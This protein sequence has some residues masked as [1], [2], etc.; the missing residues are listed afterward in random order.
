MNKILSKSKS[1]TEKLGLEFS[2]KLKPRDVVCLYGELGSGKTTF[3]KGLARG[4]NVR[5][6]VIS[7]TFIIIRTHLVA[8]S[9]E[10][11]NLYHVD[12]YRL[13]N[14]KQIREVGIKDLLRDKKGVTLIE[15]PEKAER[16][17]PSN[18]WEIFFTQK[19]VSTREIIIHKKNAKKKGS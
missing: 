16:L 1:Q 4:L 19:D 5:S 10:I 13:E 6:R 7:P 8:G 14:L 3:V 17:L 15:W 12:L 9:E 18:R 11:D 2:K